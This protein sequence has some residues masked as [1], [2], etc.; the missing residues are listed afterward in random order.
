MP[1]C[2]LQVFGRCQC[3]HH[4]AGDHC[5][6]C[7]P[8]YNDRRWR[9]ANSSSGEPH[10]CQSERDQQDSRS[11]ADQRIKRIDSLLSSPPWLQSASAT[12]TLTAVTSPSKRGSLRAA[13]A[14]GF[15][16]TASTTRSAAGAS[17]VAMV[18]TVSSPCPSARHTHAN[19]REG[20]PRGA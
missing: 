4:T 3:A 11:R 15:A 10:P 1:R 7:A 5:E 6:K 13:P 17:A 20:Q 9:P 16:I 18:T 8:L 19:V 2:V 12:A 14:G